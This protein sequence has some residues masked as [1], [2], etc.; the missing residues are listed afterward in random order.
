MEVLF[1]LINR[2]INRVSVNLPYAMA[3]LKGSY[4]YP[5]LRGKVKFYGYKEGSLIRVEVEGL[6][7][8]NK[9][10]FF[11][12]HIHEG[13]RCDEGETPFESAGGHLNLENDQH[14]N[15][16]GDLPVIYSNN[17]YAYIEFYTSR[18]N[19]E[20]VVDSVVIIHKEKDD[21]KTEPAGNSGDRIA[22]GKILRLKI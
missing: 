8:E 9:N 10:N 19:P 14:P 7:N 21:L 11:G 17:G 12:F 22:C 20:I 15:H 6:P 3:E 4:K 18:F 13:Y 1:S 16:L 5:K 2:R